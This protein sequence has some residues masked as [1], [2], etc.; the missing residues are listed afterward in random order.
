MIGHTPPLLPSGTTGIAFAGA[1]GCGKTTLCR[2]IQRQLRE[3]GRAC[4]IFSFAAPLKRM[5]EK[6]LL[7]LDIPL[8]ATWKYQHRKQL[9]VL[10]EAGRAEDP[11]LWVYLLASAVTN[12][13]RENP[14]GVAL[15]DDMRYE[16]EIQW[17]LGIQ[18]FKVVKIEPTVMAML[19]RRTGAP[20]AGKADSHE[21]EHG[22]DHWTDWDLVL[23]PISRTTVTDLAAILSERLPR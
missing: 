11:G 19:E 22:L 13:Y 7:S 1:K 18:G 16:N 21:S 15:V 8:S 20:D 14:D 23:Y 2:E 5:A 10:G 3:E 17:L 12:F 6:L 4:E 9:Q